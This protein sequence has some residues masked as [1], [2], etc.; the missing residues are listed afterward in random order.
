MGSDVVPVTASAGF[1]CPGLNIRCFQCFLRACGFQECLEV[2]T[3]REVVLVLYIRHVDVH[4]K[5]RNTS[6]LQACKRQE[7]HM[8]SS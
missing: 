5:L 2:A 1:W 4:A 7:L 6:I 8:R 3:A